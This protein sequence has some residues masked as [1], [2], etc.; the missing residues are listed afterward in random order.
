MTITIIIIITIQILIEKVFVLHMIPAS[1]LIRL[2]S[3]YVFRFLV[4]W[5]WNDFSFKGIRDF[6]CIILFVS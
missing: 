2:I 6:Y 3:V 1:Y 4:F 5:N